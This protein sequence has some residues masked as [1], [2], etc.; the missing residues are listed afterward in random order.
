MLGPSLRAI[1]ATIEGKKKVRRTFLMYLHFMGVVSHDE[2]IEGYAAVGEV[3]FNESGAQPDAE[4]FT[5][6]GEGPLSTNMVKVITLLAMQPMVAGMDINDIKDKTNAGL[7]EMKYTYFEIMTSRSSWRPMRSSLSSWGCGLATT[8]P[9]GCSVTTPRCTT[10]EWCRYELGNQRSSS[11]SATATSHHVGG[12]LGPNVPGTLT[13]PSPTRIRGSRLRGGIFQGGRERQALHA[14]C[15]LNGSCGRGW[16]WRRWIPWSLA[17]RAGRAQWGGE[18]EEPKN[19][20][21]GSS[22]GTRLISEPGSTTISKFGSATSS[23]SSRTRSAIGTRVP[24]WFT[25]SRTGWGGT[26]WHSPSW[27][28]LGGHGRLDGAVA[29][30]TTA[31][32]WED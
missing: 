7:V 19:S 9:R 1:S 31:P 3:E 18:E 21:Y 12:W 26:S 20:R 11:I 17:G 16:T 14:S 2:I 28:Q 15:D 4:H 10:R 8:T 13:I 32:C 25:S 5:D 23:T 24:T 6:G 30:R 29:Q 27:D 22:S